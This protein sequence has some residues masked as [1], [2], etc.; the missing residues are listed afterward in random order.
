MRETGKLGNC[1]KRSV[2]RDLVKLVPTLS[3]YAIGQRLRRKAYVISS[4]TTKKERPLLR[5]FSNSIGLCLGHLSSHKALTYGLVQ[6]LMST[7]NKVQS[8]FFTITAHATMKSNDFCDVTWIQMKW[9][10]KKSLKWVLAIDELSEQ[11]VHLIKRIIFYSLL[12]KVFKS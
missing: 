2:K 6:Q 11:S 12:S 1:R 3:F 7:V 10:T 9:L 8:H 5:L 4:Y